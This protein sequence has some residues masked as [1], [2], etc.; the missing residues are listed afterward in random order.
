MFEFITKCI[1]C[2]NKCYDQYQC[3]FSESEYVIRLPIYL[4]QTSSLSLTCY[5]WQTLSVWDECELATYFKNN[6][7]ASHE[8]LIEFIDSVC[9]QKSHRYTNGYKLYCTNG[10]TYEMKVYDGMMM[11]E[12]AFVKLEKEV[13]DIV[14]NEVDEATNLL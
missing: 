4:E 10:D 11:T 5:E 8:E 3:Q 9:M 13:A 6:C 2:T 14:I 12:F 7:I 1:S